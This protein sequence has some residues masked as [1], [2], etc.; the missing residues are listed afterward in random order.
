MKR[1]AKEANLQI[2][3]HLLVTINLSNERKF[4]SMGI[5]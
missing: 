1:I 2:F 4:F 3:R 5:L